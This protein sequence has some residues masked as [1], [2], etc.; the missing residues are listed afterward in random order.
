[1]SELSAAAAAALGVPEA[2]VLRSAAARAADTGMSVDEVLS[3]WAGGE[4]VAAPAPSP[5][6]TPKERRRR[7]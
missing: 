1:M 7:R 5:R 4:L 3:A 2:I 6:A